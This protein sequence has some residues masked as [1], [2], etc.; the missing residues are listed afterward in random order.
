MVD[1]MEFT[2]EEAPGGPVE[3]VEVPFKLDGR[4]LVAYVPTN[5]QISLAYRLT[6]RTATVADQVAGSLDLLEHCMD[7]Q[8]FAHIQGRLLDPADPFDLNTGVGG[9]LSWLLTIWRE[10]TGAPAQARHDAAIPARSPRKATPKKAPAKKAPAKAALRA[11][12]AK[13]A[14]GRGRVKTTRTR[15]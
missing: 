7:A 10:Q 1:V 13:K 12:P 14:P 5:I 4:M 11:A 15:T 9:I 8:S 3:R 6:S 2:T